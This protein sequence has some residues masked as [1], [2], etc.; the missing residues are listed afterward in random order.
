MS[1]ISER[2][3]YIK[4]ILLIFICINNSRISKSVNVSYSMVIVVLFWNIRSFLYIRMR[5]FNSYANV[6][7]DFIPN[8]TRIIDNPPWFGSEE[9]SCWWTQCLQ[10]FRFWFGP[11]GII[12]ERIKGLLRD[13]SSTP[14]IFRSLQSNT[15]RFLAQKFRQMT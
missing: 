12:R 1:D 7:Y 11:G 2:S 6:Y 3:G 4:L 13:I 5:F 9:H 14:F 8:N 15:Y 10:S